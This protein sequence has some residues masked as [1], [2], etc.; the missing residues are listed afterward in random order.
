MDYKT[1]KFNRD[2]AIARITLARP[3]AANALNFDMGEELNEVATICR[4][5]TSIRTVILDAESK[6]FCAG[7][8]VLTFAAAG[9]DLPATLRKLLDTFHPAVVTLSTM[10][11]PVIASVQGVAAGAGLSLLSSCSFVI[12]S[13]KASFMMAYTGIGMSPDGSATYFLPRQIGLRRAEEMMITNRRLSAVEAEQWGLVNQV[14]P[15]DQLTKVTQQLAEQIAQGPTLAY[16]TTRRL[17]LESFDNSFLQQLDAEEKAIIDMAKTSD[18]LGGIAAFK[19][20][21]KPVFG[22]Q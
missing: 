13:E 4:D 22:G 18:G 2:G 10:N 1:I 9:K 5:D 16:G 17:L 12:A 19:E 21:R 7:G 8:D 6:I 15:A 20:K 11:A 14:T 3:D